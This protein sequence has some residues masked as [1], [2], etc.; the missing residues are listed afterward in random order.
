MK[1]TWLSILFVF[2]QFLCLA[3]IGFTGPIFANPLLL[4]LIEIKWLVPG[5]MGSPGNANWSF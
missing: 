4:L 1:P 2:I 5:D 3:L